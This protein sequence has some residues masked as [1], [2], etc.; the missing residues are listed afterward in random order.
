M[1][2]IGTRGEA[3][4]HGVNYGKSTIGRRSDFLIPMQE[5]SGSNDG[6][7]TALAAQ[8]AIAL[9]SFVG[10]DPFRPAWKRNKQTC[11][12]TTGSEVP[13]VKQRRQ[14]LAIEALRLRPNPQNLKR[15]RSATQTRNPCQSVSLAG[16]IEH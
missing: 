15:C 8:D 6:G 4:A 9:N 16:V 7:A 10:L 14:V 13:E 5:Y 2:S 3:Q 11:F 12:D 1:L